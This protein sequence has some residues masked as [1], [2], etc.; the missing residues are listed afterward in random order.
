MVNSKTKAK[1]LRGCRWALQNLKRLVKRRRCQFDSVVTEDL[2]GEGVGV[3][4]DEEKNVVAVVAKRQDALSALPFDTLL[5]VFRTLEIYDVLALS[6]VSVLLG[7]WFSLT[8][9]PLTMD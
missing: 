3:G 8:F 7:R 1:A 4:Q 9:L 5:V 6:Q 2:E